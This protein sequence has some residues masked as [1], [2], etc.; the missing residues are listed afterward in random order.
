MLVE[1]ID[2]GSSLN[3]SGHLLE[4]QNDKFGRFEGCEA[5]PDIDY[6][7][8]A[9]ALSRRFVIAFYEVRIARC[10]SLKRALAEKIV[11]ERADV[12]PNLRP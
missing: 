10:G 3:L 12:E 7:E 11:H 2:S 9:I 1:I 5:D 6:A 8:I 4:I